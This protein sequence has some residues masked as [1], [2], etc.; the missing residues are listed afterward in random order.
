MRGG[1]IKREG[2]ERRSFVRL[3]SSGGGVGRQGRFLLGGTGPCGKE[4]PCGSQLVL[5]TIFDSG[6]R[7]QGR[8]GMR[9][10]E[11]HSDEEHKDSTPLLR[12]R[13]YHRRR[14]FAWRGHNNRQSE[15]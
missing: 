10:K 11:Q 1:R 13:Q 4:V 15:I 12:W 3:C 8:R 5:A 9:G 6:R 7:R 14:L 2:R